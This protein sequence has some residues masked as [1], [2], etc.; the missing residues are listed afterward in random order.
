MVQFGMRRV[1]SAIDCGS[2]SVRCSIAEASEHDWAPVEDAEYPLDLLE[3]IRRK[4][5]T[6]S[7][8]ERLLQALRDTV[9]LGRT[10]GVSA[11]RAVATPSLR[12]VANVDVLLERAKLSLG[13]DVELIDG[14]EE[15]R[16]Y[17]QALTW[18]LGQE[19]R[20]LGGDLLLMDLGSATSSVS[21]IRDSNLVQTLEEHVGTERFAFSFGEHKD[22][23]ILPN[24]LDRLALGASKVLI[25]RLYHPGHTGPQFASVL[26]TGRGPR[27]LVKLLGAKDESL[28]PSLSL[29]A[30]DETFMM[31]SRLSPLE[32]AQWASE[33]T[34]DIPGLLSSLAIMRRIGAAA[35][36]E[37]VVVPELRLRIGLLFDFCQVHRAHIVCR[38]NI[39]LR[40]QVSSLRVT[41]WTKIIRRTPQRSP[42]RFFDATRPLHHLDERSRLLLEIASLVHDVGAHI[43]VRSRHRHSFYILRNADWSGLNLR[44]REIVAQI[45]RYHRG[46]VPMGLTEEGA[47]LDRFERMQLST[48]AAILRVAYALDVERSQRI[49]LLKCTISKNVFRIETEVQDVALECW[50]MARKSGL[51]KSVFGLEVQV[52]PEQTGPFRAQ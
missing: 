32:R 46:K 21:W 13:L 15:G 27:E 33:S 24:C 8:M 45:A 49:K 11:V 9:E 39:W 5:F 12:E 14:A 19:E 44:E 4:R 6:R 35:G 29:T 36:V 10:Y 16:L 52:V 17:H 50:S 1:V 42:F 23:A 20:H 7:E 2:T 25:N 38:V 34:V 3:A 18:V 28:L 43:S 47:H 37:R 41:A 31:L 30:L 22:E 40:Q 51:F 48:L 26:V